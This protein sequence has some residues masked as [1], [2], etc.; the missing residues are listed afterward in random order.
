MRDKQI[1][2]KLETLSF[3]LSSAPQF[4]IPP[5]EPGLFGIQQDEA[6]QTMGSFMAQVI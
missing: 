6:A 2:V 1:V 5:A 3:L 4:F